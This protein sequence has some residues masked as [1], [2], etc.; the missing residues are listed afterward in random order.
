MLITGQL[1]STVDLL[2]YAASLLVLVTF[3]MQTMVPLRCVA[4]GSNVLFMTYG[5]LDHIYPVMLLHAVLLPVNFARLFQI[6]KLIR[7]ASNAGEGRFSIE[8]LMPFMTRRH[9]RPGDVLLRK[10]ELADKMYYLTE[11]ELKIADIDKVVLPG[12]VIGEI[13]VF[14]PD[15]FRTAT[16]VCLT[17][18]TVYELSENKAKEL[19]FQNPG[20][21]YAVLQLIIARLLEN[22]N[23]TTQLRQPGTAPCLE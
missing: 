8:S 17:P 9:L 14:A 16:V 1:V 3:C 20:F 23:Q 12:N 11:G 5:Y 19:Y 22:Q 6:K 21:G 7:D 18:C 15:H 13:G 4:L 2:G 10:G